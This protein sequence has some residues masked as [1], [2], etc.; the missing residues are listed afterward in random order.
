M[1]RDMDQYL[2]S[3]RLILKG[4]FSKLAINQQPIS[5]ILL[6]VASESD[7]AHTYFHLIDEC[8]QKH[9]RFAIFVIKL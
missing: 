8:P 1:K 9:H 2:S 6:C 3:Y 4:D 7:L 5:F